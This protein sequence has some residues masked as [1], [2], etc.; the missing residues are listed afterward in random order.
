[1]LVEYATNNPNMTEKFITKI[2]PPKMRL[3]WYDIKMNILLS[4]KSTC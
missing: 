3:G 1:M 4:N 2:P